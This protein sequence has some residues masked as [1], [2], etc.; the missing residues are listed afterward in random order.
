MVLTASTSTSS[1]RLSG[2]TVRWRGGPGD[3]E[4]GRGGGIR[5][6]HREGTGREGPGRGTGRLFLFLFCNFC[7]FVATFARLTLQ[8]GELWLVGLCRASRA[9]RLLEFLFIFSCFF[10]FFECASFHFFMFFFS[11]NEKKTGEKKKSKKNRKK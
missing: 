5:K 7:I 6:R 9:W 1:S 2:T 4:G 10:F 11:K 8:T 3:R